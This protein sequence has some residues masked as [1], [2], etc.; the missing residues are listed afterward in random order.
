MRY[1]VSVQPLRSGVSEETVPFD[2]CVLALGS[3]Y[4]GVIKPGKQE[5]TLH[6]RARTWQV[7]TARILLSCVRDIPCM[8]LI[9]FVVWFMQE[10]SKEVKAASTIVVLG[11][12]LCLFPR[13]RLQ[14]GQRTHAEDPVDFDSFVLRLQRVWSGWSWSESWCART[15]R[16]QST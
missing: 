10:A 7:H 16:R 11:G 6:D 4:S 2:V 14:H 5:P 3:S 15:R 1:Q 13:L 12:R 8:T 9:L